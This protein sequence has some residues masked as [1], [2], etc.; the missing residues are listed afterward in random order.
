[1]ADERERRRRRRHDVVTRSRTP[2][3][4]SATYCIVMDCSRR[5]MAAAGR[6]LN[7]RLCRLHEDRHER[8]GSPYRGS[9]SAIIINPYRRAAFDWMCQHADD[10]WVNN[11]VAGIA[12][13]YK[14]SGPFVEAFRLRGLKPEERARAAWAR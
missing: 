8:H 10:F 9:Y 5:T 3:T 2:D 7:R 11:A 14:N 13:L 6:G 1:M 4:T 12:A